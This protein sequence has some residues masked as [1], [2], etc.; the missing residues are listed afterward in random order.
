M[1]MSVVHRG[2]VCG[3]L[4]VLPQVAIEPFALFIAVFVIICVFRKRGRGPV[5]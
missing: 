2:H 4:V 5:C 1:S 3:F